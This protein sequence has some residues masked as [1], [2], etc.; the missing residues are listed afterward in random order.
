MYIPMVGDLGLGRQ[1]QVHSAFYI[2]H[3]T[4]CI[5]ILTPDS[6]S[7]I[8]TCSA[9]RWPL[10]CFCSSILLLWSLEC[11]NNSNSNSNSNNDNDKN[12]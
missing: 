12:N 9:P 7:A 1:V 4:F 8:R 3:S 10:V 6:D 2:Q 11:A 5:L